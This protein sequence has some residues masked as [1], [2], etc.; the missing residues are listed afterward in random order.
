MLKVLGAILLFT[1]SAQAAEP[2]WRYGVG[3]AT[4][5]IV[6][7]TTDSIPGY[8]PGDVPFNPM[9]LGWHF[10]WNWRSG[11]LV[12]GVEYMP[13]VGGWSPGIHPT[14]A[15]IQSAYIA[16]PTEFPDGTTWLIGN[17]VIWDDSRSPAQYAQ[18]YHDY[19]YGLKGINPT[20]KVANGSI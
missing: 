12:P 14:L 4:Q 20:W 10:N 9:G 15:Q 18:D 19:Y 16:N 5:N 2:R 11:P 6:C 8:R 1:L 17:E 13:L 7:G 3:V